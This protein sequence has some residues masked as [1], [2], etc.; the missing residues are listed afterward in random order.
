MEKIGHQQSRNHQHKCV[1]YFHKITQPKQFG[2]GGK[3]KK[4]VMMPPWIPNE[5]L[6]VL[7]HVEGI[8]PHTI[9]NT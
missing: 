3:I 7:H 4:T 5:T 9:H 2:G 1:F 8:I 6:N